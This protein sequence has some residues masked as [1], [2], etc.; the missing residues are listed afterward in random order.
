[1]A[2][3][4]K[5]QRKTAGAGA[6]RRALVDAAGTAHAPTATGARIVSLVPS[7]TELLFALGLGGKVVGR[8][9]FCVHPAD[10]VAGVTSVGGTKRVNMERLLGLGPTHVVVNIDENPKPL[11]DA[12]TARGITVVVT[13]PIAV[14][15]NVALYRLIGG[16]FGAARAT[17]DLV[18]RFEA[19]LAGVRAAARD[20]PA[21]N[22]LYLIW[23]EPWMT[24]GADTY[25][26]KLLATVN[27]RTVG[28]D[29]RTRY[30]EPRLD[31]GFLAGV[32]LVLLASEPY[33]F[34]AA[35]AA[36]FAAE[37]PAH[38]DKT[39]LVDGQLL[40]WYGSRAILGLEYLLGLATAET[41]RR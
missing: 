41:A 14:E 23:K 11:A 8:T 26:S 36:A 2:K 19:A 21:R 16:V 6:P 3:T 35:D 37:F 25:I 18:R 24:V 15:D 13:H 30:P 5:K 10:A 33:A 27:W 29:P 38:A 34:S 7:V 40:S 20:L 31:D 39:R 1:M 4:T 28:D 32:D 17:E 12:L 9:A 22:V